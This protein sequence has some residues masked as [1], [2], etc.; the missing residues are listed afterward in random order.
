MIVPRAVF[1][2]GF[3]WVTFPKALAGSEVPEREWAK[4]KAKYITPHVAQVIEL[5]D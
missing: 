4:L 2:P 1:V 3:G 5:K